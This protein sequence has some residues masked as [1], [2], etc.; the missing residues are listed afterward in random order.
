MIIILPRHRLVAAA[1]IE[2]ALEHDADESLSET[3]PPTPLV[4]G[5]STARNLH[6]RLTGRTLF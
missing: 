1:L 2:A 5:S 3:T 4:P 6:H